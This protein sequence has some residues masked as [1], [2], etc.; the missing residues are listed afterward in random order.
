MP[1]SPDQD[2][3][4]PQLPAHPPEPCTT[5]SSTAWNKNEEVTARLPNDPEVSTVVGETLLKQVY[6]QVRTAPPRQH[7]APSTGASA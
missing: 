2:P 6:D 4:S 3:E 7:E 5:P 1:P